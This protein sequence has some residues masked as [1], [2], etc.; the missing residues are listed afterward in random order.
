[1]FGDVHLTG[2]DCAQAALLHHLAPGVVVGDAQGEASA[3]GLGAWTPRGALADAVLL[4]LLLLLLVILL[5]RL[6]LIPLL[7]ILLLP[8]WL[9]LL[10]LILLAFISLL[11]LLLFLLLRLL[12]LLLL[13]LL[14][15]LQRWLLLQFRLLLL[16]SGAGSHWTNGNRDDMLRLKHAIA[17]NSMASTCSLLEVN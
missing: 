8:L 5:L 6:L 14:L 1:M 4:L 13:L 2:P 10:I 15:F 9:L 7:S 17:A 3:A 16:L 12:L 11:W